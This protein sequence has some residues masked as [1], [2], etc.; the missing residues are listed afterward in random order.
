MA[1]N[2]GDLFSCSLQLG[3]LPQGNEII[4]GKAPKSDINN[5]ENKV[6]LHGKRFYSSCTHCTHTC[7]H[8]LMWCFG[9]KKVRPSITAGN[10]TL[11]DFAA[12]VTSYSHTRLVK[13]PQKTFEKRRQNFEAIVQTLCGSIERDHTDLSL[14][15]TYHKNWIPGVQYSGMVIFFS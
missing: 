6:V 14:P 15:W 5:S 4:G 1:A 10:A 3:C 9:L 2:R 12:F 7:N 11:N 13:S 8:R